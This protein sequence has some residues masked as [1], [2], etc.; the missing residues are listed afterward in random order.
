MIL[1]NDVFILNLVV[2]L[3]FFSNTRRWVIV[4][5]VLVTF[6]VKF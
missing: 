3:Y 5:Y 2:T 1:T 4:K 6:N